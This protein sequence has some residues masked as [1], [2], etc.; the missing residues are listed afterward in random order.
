MSKF[1][2]TNFK[3]LLQQSIPTSL[4]IHTAAL[5]HHCREWLDL[6]L[7]QSIPTSLLI[8]SRAFTLASPMTVHTKED[9]SFMVIRDAI[10]YLP[11]EVVEVRGDEG[12]MAWGVG[13]QF[14]FRRGLQWGEDAASSTPLISL[15]T[16]GGGGRVDAPAS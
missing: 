10:G 9:R 8:L 12:M 5:S 6:S 16:P 14:W 3:L 2:W 7:Q 15:P 1:F 13:V 4:L 11:E